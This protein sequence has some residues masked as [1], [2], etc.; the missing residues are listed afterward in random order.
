[1]KHLDNNEDSIASNIYFEGFVLINTFFVCTLKHSKRSKFKAKR[2]LFTCLLFRK[3][4]DL[5]FDFIHCI[6]LEHLPGQRQLKNACGG[7]LVTNS[8]KKVNKVLHVA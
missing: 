7:T 2:F 6:S 1:M 5:Q 8:E 3:Q 4:L